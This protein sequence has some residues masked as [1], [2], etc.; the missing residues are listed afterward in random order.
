MPAHQWKVP[1][2]LTADGNHICQLVTPPSTQVPLGAKCPATVFP[3]AEGAGYYRFAEDEAGWASLIATAPRLDPADQ[4]TLFHNVDAAMRGGY[5]TAT[6]YFAAIRALAPVAQWDLLQGNR[7]SGLSLPNSLRDLRVTGVIAPADV[8]LLQAFVRKM[9]DPRL[10]PLG[11]AAKPDEAPADT[12]LRQYLVTLLVEEGNDRALIAQLTK[13][14]HVYLVSDGK[15]LGGI[16]P[17]LVQEAMTAGVVSEG[18]PFANV[19]MEALQNSTDEYFVQSAIYAL[20]T[21][22]DESVL[23]KLL[24][25]SLTP[26]I[27]T[28]D[29][30]YVFRYMQAEAKGR[31]AAWAWFKQNYDG[32]L[33]RVSTEGMSSTPDI[34]SYGCDAAAS[35]DLDA[36]FGPKTGQ[37]VG[38]PRTLTEND[39]RIARCIAFK[40]AKAGEISAALKTLK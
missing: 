26:A 6:D 15:D 31:D 34:L 8:P 16:A 39:D 22:D 23:R 35:A 40:N 32:V 5:G 1:M 9:F 4:L 10:T 28:G 25:L 18:V 36:F 13:A 11:L 17:E 3:N 2:C 12:L 21:S 24:D 37:L 29:M 20:A 30:H 14:A 19:L 27:R 38:T 7:R 33:K